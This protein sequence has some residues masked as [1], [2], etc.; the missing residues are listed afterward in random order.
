MEIVNYDYLYNRIVLS[1]I[2]D[3]R[4]WLL[5]TSIFLPWVIWWWIVDK[6]RVFEILAYGL[7][8]AAMATWLDLLGTE[9]GKWSYPFKLNTDIQTLLPADSAVIPVM[10]MILYQYV[11]TWKRFVIGSVLCAAVLSFIFEPLFM[12]L[13]MLELKEWTHMKSFFSFISL[14]LA[15]KTLFSFINKKQSTF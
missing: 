12:M 6:K 1:S 10:Y 3:P 13:D 15:T 8:W 4:W 11:S 2:A 14:A 9:Y 5:L 7:C